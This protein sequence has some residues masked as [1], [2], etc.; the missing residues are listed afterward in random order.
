MTRNGVFAVALFLAG[1]LCGRFAWTP[2]VNAQ[3]PS[4]ESRQSWVLAPAPTSR[5]YYDA[6]IYN[7]DTGAVYGLNER[8]R[9]PLKDK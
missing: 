6:F 2:A 8:G 3:Q 9:V 7:A 5:G 4:A 1:L